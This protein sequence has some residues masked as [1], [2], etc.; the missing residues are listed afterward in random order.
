LIRKI[1]VEE[2]KEAAAS[3]SVEMIGT[4]NETVHNAV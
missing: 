4:L 1:D 3:S 2:E